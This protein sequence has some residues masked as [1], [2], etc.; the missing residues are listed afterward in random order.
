MP[1]RRETR[2]RFAVLVGKYAGQYSKVIETLKDGLVNSIS[3]YAY[4]RLDARKIVLVNMLEC[5]NGGDTSVKQQGKGAAAC[6]A[7]RGSSAK[8]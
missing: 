2:E 7:R 6:S 5:L 3:L 1:L 4:P 8:Q